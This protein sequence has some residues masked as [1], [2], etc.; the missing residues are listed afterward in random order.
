M[1]Y[2]EK[3]LLNQLAFPFSFLFSICITTAP[4]ESSNIYHFRAF[5]DMCKLGL[6]APLA[7]KPFSSLA[8]PGLH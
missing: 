7:Y 6:V 2:T 8:G 1:L 4:L 3:I 5:S